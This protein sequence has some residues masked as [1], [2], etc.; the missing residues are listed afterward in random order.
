MIETAQYERIAELRVAGRLED[1]IREAQ[2]LLA[3]AGSDDEKAPLLTEMH[4][5]CV[6]LGRLREARRILEQIGR[7]EVVNLE[8]RMNAEFCEAAQLI[9]EGRYAEGASAF[10]AMLERHRDALQEDRFRYLYEDIQSR[11]AEALVWLSRFKEALPILREAVH[12][13]Y[14]EAWIEQRIWRYLGMCLEDAGDLEEAR[15]AYERVVT[16]GL[17]NDFEE[18]VLWRLSV[19]HWNKGALAQAKEHLERILRDFPEPTGAVPR[20]QVYDL[21]GRCF[22]FL[23]DQAN[24]KV[25]ADL[26]KRV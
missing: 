17:R 4:V 10:A 8:I 13:T 25:Y 11:R 15:R 24:E 20:K 21:L 14:D 19:I 6:K 9:H 2:A 5:C 23:G 3:E 7:L 22:H 26:A 1:C 18:K 12:F 16:F